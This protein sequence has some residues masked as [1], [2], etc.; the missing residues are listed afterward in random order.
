LQNKPCSQVTACPSTTKL[1]QPS[2]STKEDTYTFTPIEP[3]LQIDIPTVKF[4][5]ITKDGQE[6]GIPYL[7]E[8]IAG[9]YKYAVA[10]GSIVA[11][12]LIMVGGLRWLTAGGSASAID[13]A[14]SRIS[15]AVIG[16]ILLLGSYTILYTINPDLVSL[17]ELQVMLIDRE[18]L[19][20]DHGSDNE[21]S[22][23]PGAGSAANCSQYDNLFKKYSPCLGADWKILKTIAAAESGCN[24]NIDNGRGYY[25]MAQ[26]RA[27]GSGGSIICPGL[28]KGTKF[29]GKCAAEDLKNPEIAIAIIAKYHKK[30]V[31]KIKKYC[32]DALPIMQGAAIHAYH[33]VPA[34]AY[35]FVKKG[36]K[37]KN[38]FIEGFLNY[39]LRT[40]NAKAKQRYFADKTYKSKYADKIN[41]ETEYLKAIAAGKI[42]YSI[43]K[44]GNIFNA[45]GGN[46]KNPAE[47]GSCP[48]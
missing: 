43:I 37:N 20:G 2:A 48:L 6:L 39:Y 18:L 32:G 44:A 45:I 12:V 22:S 42:D 1:Q 5:K 10:I 23:P 3:K 33:N 36:C 29:A 46:M 8:Y 21:L 11:I 26:T 35:N 7:A 25:G 19:E 41:N 38:D 40:R 27:A 30:K 31:A 17:K 13:A 15:N 34:G 16:L 4:S 47:G 24:A 28:L 9:I 14:K